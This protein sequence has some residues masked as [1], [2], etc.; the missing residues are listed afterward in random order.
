MRHTDIAIVGA[1][2]AGSVAAAMCARAGWGVLAVDP[3][4]TYPPDFR[5]EKLDESQIRTMQ[6][7]GLEECLLPHATRN[8]T[9]WVAR[10][11]IYVED[12]RRLQYGIRYDTLVNSFRAAIPRGS[13]IASKVSRIASSADVQELEL[14][15]GEKISARL[16]IVA[17]GLNNALRQSLGI[18]RRELSKNHSISIGF[19]IAPA[20]AEAFPFTALT[21]H[22]ERAADRVAYL[23]LFPIGSATR[24]NFFVYRD[25]RDPWLERMR[26]AP[27][28]TLFETLP[29]LKPIIGA[30]KIEG[31]VQIRPADLVE[32]ENVR[33]PGIVL[34]GD[35]FSTSCPAAGA[36]A[37]KVFTDVERLCNVYLPQ[38][39]KTPGMG[40]EKIAAYYDDSIKMASDAQSTAK[41]WYLRSLCTEAGL[42]WLTRRWVKFAVH[43]GVGMMGSAAKRL[44]A[45]PDPEAA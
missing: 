23:T 10:N 36:G 7:T 29:G 26:K 5:C 13:L 15:N 28:E 3:H 21:Y 16:V 19:D 2:L 31:D 41:A 17:T 25:I 6:K 22:S 18:T 33:K 38:W 35:A 39:L 20:D 4:E 42:A 9:L 11:G 30:V 45:R 14:S 27:V 32:A 43:A 34:V 37:G 40:V 8:E 44:S 24:A 12:Q 1:G